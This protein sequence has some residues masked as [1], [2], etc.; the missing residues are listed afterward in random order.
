MPGEHHAEF[1]RAWPDISTRVGAMLRR[2]G[3]TRDEVDDVLQETA[4]RLLR[5]WDRLDPARPAVP[6]AAAVALNVVRAGSRDRPPVDALGDLPESPAP[7]DVADAATA[8]IE[9]ERVLGAVRKLSPGRRSA[10]LEEIGG[11]P[12]DGDRSVAAK[13]MLRMRAR[14]DLRRMLAGAW[15]VPGRA[16]D[17][18]RQAWRS[19][20]RG[21][22]PS[23][24]GSIDLGVVAA[25]VVGGAVALAG[26]FGD[27]GPGNAAGPTPVVVS[28]ERADTTTLVVQDAGGRGRDARSARLPVRSAAGALPGEAA[29]TRTPAGAGHP[30]PPPPPGGRQ[31]PSSPP[32]APPAPTPPPEPS[33]APPP[34]A[35]PSPPSHPPSPPP[36]PSPPPRPRP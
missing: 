15:I 12:A 9:L 26:S 20:Q 11:S 18:A 22:L 16:V 24:P 19:L 17:V 30:T 5:A 1:Q 29:D 10:L 3:L 32:S 8:R 33:G 21:A 28:P 36:N 25:T 34:P 27:L 7:D 2:R 6:F 35:N 14:A 23:S 4:L 31:R 13:K